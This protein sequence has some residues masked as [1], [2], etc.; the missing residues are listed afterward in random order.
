ML[1]RLI[2]QDMPPELLKQLKL[3][4]QNLNALVIN[5]EGET[6]Q[7]AEQLKNSVELL[8]RSLESFLLEQSQNPQAQFPEKSLL[9]LVRLQQMLEQ[10]G[11]KEGARAVRDFLADIQRNQFMNVKPDPVPG[12][13]V[14]T[15]VGFML[16]GAQQKV[17]QQFSSARLRIAHEAKSDSDKINPAYTRLILQVDLSPDQTVEVDLSLVGKQIRTS[18]MAPDPL[19]CDKAQGE[20]PSLVEALHSLGYDLKDV[21]IGVGDPRPFGGIAAVLQSDTLM[22]VNIEV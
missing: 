15:E 7:L 2:Q 18:L 17:D 19:W 6:P 4:L 22:T 3:S 12:S 13:G 1:S 20:L 8:G 9:S 14:W 10:L 11:Q 16:Q 21:Q 5:G